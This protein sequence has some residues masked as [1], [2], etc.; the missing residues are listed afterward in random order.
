MCAGLSI[1]RARYIRVSTF[2]IGILTMRPSM[3]GARIVFSSSIDTL[4]RSERRA[5]EMAARDLSR[6]NV[7]LAIIEF[8]DAENRVQPRRFTI[9]GAVGFVPVI[10]IQPSPCSHS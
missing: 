3:A 6:S 8:D 2:R 4:V 10:L 9:A 7:G 1:T 5:A